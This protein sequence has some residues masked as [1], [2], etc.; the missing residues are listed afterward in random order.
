MIALTAYKAAPVGV[1][2]L[3]K[4]GEATIA[5]LCAG[6]AE[7]YAW[8]DRPAAA[9]RERVHMLDFKQWPWQRLK[10]LVLSPGVP[11]THPQPHPVVTMAKQFW[12]AG[13]RRRGAALA[14]LSASA[15]RGYYRY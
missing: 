13:D 3:G 8:D 5:A 11:L 7:V 2:G 6:G 15:F 4:A 1:F 14:S 12:R 9:S 10:A